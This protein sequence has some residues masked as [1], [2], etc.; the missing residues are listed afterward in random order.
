MQRREPCAD[1]A[2]TGGDRRALLVG[3]DGVAEL[4]LT[5]ERRTELIDLLGDDDRLKAEYPKVAEYLEMAPQLAGTGNLQV[6][7]AFELRIV[8]YMTCARA[9]SP[10]PYWDIVSPFV[11]DRD[12]R[13]VVDG[14]NM[15]GSPRLAFAQM[16]LQ[17][18]YTYALP[19]PE[20]L[21]WVAAFCGGRKVVELGA[22]RGYWAAQMTRAGVE[23]EAYD[24][25]PPDSTENV[26]F[27]RNAGQEDIWHPVGDLGQFDMSAADRSNQVL[28]L[29]WPPGWGNT[30]A[31]EALAAF[32]QAGGSRLIFI[33]QPKGGMTGDDAFFDAL[34][35]GWELESE[36]P[37]Y[38]AWWNVADV[39][40]GWVRR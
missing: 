35:T 14:G 22:G 37:K 36:D 15:D 8:H 38:A 33:G 29:C 25:E 4:A 19:S 39:A 13:R 16:L 28:F 24:I 23:V 40:Q 10:N 18:V 17:G 5:A 9:D 1:F 3:I 7:A 27:P 30:M 2:V 21:E 34:S 12:G 32:E 11:S 26:S 20:T 6:D 31:S